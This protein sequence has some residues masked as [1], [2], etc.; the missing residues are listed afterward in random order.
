MLVPILD[1][2]PKV[3]SDLHL[4]QEIVLP[5]FPEAVMS[6]GLDVGLDLQEYLCAFAAVRQSDWLFVMP[7]RPKTGQVASKWMIAI[8]LLKL[9][10]MS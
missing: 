4:K 10:T 1:F 6:Q 5:S 7:M 8:W 3:S 9:I 2:I